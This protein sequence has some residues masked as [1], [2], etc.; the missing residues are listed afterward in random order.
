M[1]KIWLRSNII[2]LHFGTEQ[3]AQMNSLGSCK[4]NLHFKDYE[5]SDH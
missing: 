5:Q 4:Q 2:R 1:Y 3:A